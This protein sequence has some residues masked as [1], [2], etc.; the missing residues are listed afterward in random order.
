MVTQLVA[1]IAVVSTFISLTVELK[2]WSVRANIF[3]ISP[4]SKW[5]VTRPDSLIPPLKSESVGM[6][7]RHLE[8]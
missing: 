5:P 4:A 3:N 2:Y 6:G 7:P 1:S 8:A